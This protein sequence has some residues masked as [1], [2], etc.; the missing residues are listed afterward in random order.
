[1]PDPYRWLEDDLSEDTADWIADQNA[2]TRSYIDAI[3]L[4][5]D[6]KN[7]V[8][9][10][11]NFER[12]TAP[13]LKVENGISIETPGFRISEFCIALRKMAAKLCSRSEHIQRGWHG[14]HVE[15]QLSEDGSLVAYNSPRAAVTGDPL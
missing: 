4:R 14:Q 10:L 7:T 6:V 2:S 5:D 3:S 9:R 8:A 13:L 11:L 1:M 15:R 12:E